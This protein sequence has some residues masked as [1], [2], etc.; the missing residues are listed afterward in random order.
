M[1]SNQTSNQNQATHSRAP[2]RPH[3][4]LQTLKQR[5]PALLQNHPVMLAYAYGSV[6]SG[7][8]TPLSDVDIA[9]VLHPDCGLTPY[10]RLELEL[11][12]AAKIDAW[13][14]IPDTDVR[15]IDT[16]PLRIQGMVLTRGVLLY[17]RDEDFRVSYEVQTRMR[18]FDFRP[19]VER[20]RQAY[21][22]RTV[23]TLREKGLYD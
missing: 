4:I 23:S 9:L 13:N 10:Q 20:M 19:T 11:E 22:E 8:L 6:A 16:A 7:C 3:E 15:T 5:L 18:Y 14:E 12:I 2:D 21:L 17:T 1:V